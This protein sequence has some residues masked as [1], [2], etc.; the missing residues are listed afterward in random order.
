VDGVDNIDCRDNFCSNSITFSF[1]WS[2]SSLSTRISAFS[3]S[4]S[5]SSEGWDAIIFFCGS[6]NLS[7]ISF[8]VFSSTCNCAW[9]SLY[10]RSSSINLSDFSLRRAARVSKV[11][12][13]SFTSFITLSL[14]VV[15]ISFSFDNSFTARSNSSRIGLLSVLTTVCWLLMFCNSSFFND[16]SNSFLV[17]VIS[18]F[19]VFLYVLFVF[20]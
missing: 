18:F 9:T 4:P 7:F 16:C 8:K 10:L 1:C 13:A 12:F 17:S 14:I 11:D 5:F 3:F 19:L 2:F 6:P 20:F 15:K